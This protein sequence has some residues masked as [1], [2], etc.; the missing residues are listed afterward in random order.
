M[1]RHVDM[2]LKSISGMYVWRSQIYKNLTTS[3]KIPF[4][5]DLIFWQLC[6][7]CLWKHSNYTKLRPRPFFPQSL[8]YS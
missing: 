1:P 5:S 4:L 2:Q 3:R 7:C 6:E 8:N